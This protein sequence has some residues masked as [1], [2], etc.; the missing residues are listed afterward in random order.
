MTSFL[1]Q[2]LCGHTDQIAFWAFAG[3]DYCLLPLKSALQNLIVLWIS[4]LYQQI[5]A[6]AN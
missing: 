5:I 3:C 6:Q 4:Y 2:P 1:D